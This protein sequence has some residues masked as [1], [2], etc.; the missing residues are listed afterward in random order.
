MQ[1]WIANITED[2]M[3]TIEPKNAATFLVNL[4]NQEIR[5]VS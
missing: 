1:K 5:V 2:L 4:S 3:K